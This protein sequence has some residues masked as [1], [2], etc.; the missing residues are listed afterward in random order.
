MQVEH[1][2]KFASDEQVLEPKHKVNEQ[3]CREHGHWIGENM[4]RNGNLCF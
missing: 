4:D 2:E 1:F 3:V